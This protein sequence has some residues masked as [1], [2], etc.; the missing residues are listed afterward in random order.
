M[1]LIKKIK[2]YLKESIGEMKKVVWPTKKQ[3]TN[4]SLIVI[5]MS[6]GTAIF[7]GILDYAFNIGLESI[8]SNNN[9]AIAGEIEQ[10]G[11]PKNVPADI[12]KIE[13]DEIE[14]TPAYP[15]KSAE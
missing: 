12:G 14:T 15:T 10:P 7:F 4:Y 2:D 13:V 6:L 3:T 9:P 8:I 1:K 5:A 11:E